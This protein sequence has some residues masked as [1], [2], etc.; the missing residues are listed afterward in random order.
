TPTAV[1]TTAP[2]TFSTA[3]T[4]VVGAGG[5]RLTATFESVGV[6]VLFGGDANG[7]AA[8][9]LAFRKAGE[10]EAAWRAGLPLWR[11]DDGSAATGGPG[12]AFYGSALLLEP[13]TQYE[14]R[15]TL[16]DPDG[17]SGPATL[18]GAVA[19]RAEE[20]AP[21]G[22]LAPTHYVRAGGDDAGAGTS[23]EAAWRT[24]E[25][26]V[27][28]A[29]A[30]AVVQVGPGFY[31]PPA[32]G[33][34]R[35]EPLAL[36]A[37]YPA[38]DDAQE[39][40]NAGRRSVVEPAAVSSPAGS[41][42]PNAGAWQRVTLLGPG[43]G[44]APAG[45]PYA[46]WR[47]AESPVAGAE[48]LG[49]AATREELP[50][51]V[52][53]WAADAYDL[54]TPAGWA[55]K[56][57][58]NRSYNYGFAA[59]G[60]DLYLRLPGDRDPN[61]LYL[62]AGAGN[63]FTV[64]GAAVR[65]SG[66]EIRQFDNG[67][68]FRAGAT[69]GVVDH[70]LLA[71]NHHGVHLDGVAGAPSAYG[72]DHVIERNRVVNSGLWSADQAARPSIPWTFVKQTITNA[73]GT[74]YRTRR[75]GGLSEAS[76]VGGQGG[77]QRVV[78]RH[79]TVE[80]TFDGV[81]GFHSGFDRY[82]MRDAD[83]HDNLFRQLVDD[84]LDVARGSI[85]YRAWNNR[86]EQTLTVLSGPADYGPVYFFRN[87]AWRTG[88]AGVAKTGEG[89][90]PG[91]TFFKYGGSSAPTARVYVLHNTLWTDRTAPDGTNGGAEWAS[92]GTREEAYYLRN[93]VLRASKH[94]FIATGTP[95]RW[96]EDFNDFSTSDASKGVLYN[97]TEYDGGPGRTVAAYRAA[98]GQG[99]HTNTRAGF[100]VT[101]DVQFQGAAAGDLRLAAGSAFRD[102]GTPVPNLSDRPG[103]DFAG[104]A[105]D[106]G[107]WEGA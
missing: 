19:T 60:R 46:V 42:G 36:V 5:L 40:A 47:W 71:G 53:H 107:A 38:V 105:P 104:A 20:I 65:V 102:A 9:A 92:P 85:N 87:T 26:A 29:P 80:G 17:V 27:R 12:A 31:A 44:G 61:A 67:V 28:A 54:A 16:T 84:G 59:F 15:V 63:A 82:S 4:L 24:L 75:V 66:L 52:A 100:T 51:R 89:E 95:G 79:N 10:G 55:E 101:S 11:T 50:E 32:A 22:A 1:A 69:F 8:A 90:G 34:V 45:A 18:E 35:R 43:R 49:Y 2:T 68:L 37:E 33:S 62:T 72:S 3:N 86:F 74:T 77:A 97:G 78:I 91:S 48:Q 41:G 58:T 70:A 57:Y 14:V 106:L 6:E 103:A 7:N 76:G 93:N 88:S 39:P 96:D 99:A 25:K 30:G 81:N 98:S 56:L 13:G 83:V 21:A 23:P 73:D 64:D 94:A